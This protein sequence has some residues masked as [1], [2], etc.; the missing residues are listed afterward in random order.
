MCCYQQL[1]A[2]LLCFPQAI[3][4]QTQCPL[5]AVRTSFPAITHALSKYLAAQ[6]LLLNFVFS[7]YLT[8]A[9]VSHKNSLIVLHRNYD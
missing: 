9:L 6:I 4:A 7:T 5:I 8:R 1:G 2:T 3:N